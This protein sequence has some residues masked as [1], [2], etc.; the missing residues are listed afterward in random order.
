[1]QIA[2]SATARVYDEG[3]RVR[4]IIR[5]DFR[6]A[7]LHYLYCQ[8]HCSRELLLLPDELILHVDRLEVVMR[9]GIPATKCSEIDFS[10][11]VREAL[12]SLAEL[13]RR[14]ILH[15]DIK[16]QNFVLIDNHFKLIDF[17]L[18]VH[19][20]DSALRTQSHFDVHGYALRQGVAVENNN[21][22]QA[23]YAFCYTCFRVLHP[24][25]Q[26]QAKEIE[27]RAGEVLVKITAD[28]VAGAIHIDYASWIQSNFPPEYHAFFAGFLGE[29]KYSSFSE[30]L[31]LLGGEEEPAN[32]D[33]WSRR[34]Y[35]IGCEMEVTRREMYIAFDNFY[36]YLSQVSEEKIEEYLRA[37]F[38][39]VTYDFSSSFAQQMIT[40]GKG[41][42]LALEV[43]EQA[44]MYFIYEYALP[45][46]WRT[47]IID[48]G[49]ILGAIAAN[50]APYV[51]IGD[52]PSRRLN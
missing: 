18:L 13:D 50:S 26:A 4:K 9:K 1:M 41:A 23:Y 21:L 37:C 43:P 31:A 11:F 20:G 46:T 10:Q 38:Y 28:A 39:H 33:H 47:K 19:R 34:L 29:E 6:R 45:G 44:H 40:T 35:V 52:R 15:G 7:Y 3:D 5:E 25:F 14:G 17:D 12:A 30:A 49:K 22:H 16:L 27:Y 2:A 42:H 36:A 8:E 32:L 48:I 24:D 51:Y